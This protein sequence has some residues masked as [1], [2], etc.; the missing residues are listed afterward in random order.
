LKKNKDGINLL[1]G[2]R[3]VTSHSNILSIKIKDTDLVN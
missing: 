1:K 3:M 2:T